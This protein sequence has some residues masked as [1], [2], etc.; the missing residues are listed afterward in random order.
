MGSK[1]SPAPN[2]A[3][4]AA[5]SSPGTIS[6]WPAL[7]AKPLASAQAADLPVSASPCATT[8]TGRALSEAAISR[9]E[10]ATDMGRA[11]PALKGRLT[12]P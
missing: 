10:C 7:P 9:S 4:T 5:P 8:R 6:S 12:K 11:F 1:V 3:S 2:R